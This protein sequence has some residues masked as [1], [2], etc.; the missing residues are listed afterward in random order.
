MQ[1]CGIGSI[2]KNGSFKIFDDSSVFEQ[3]SFNFMKQ[4]S[5]KTR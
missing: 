4:H 1:W 5:I 3:K 2:I